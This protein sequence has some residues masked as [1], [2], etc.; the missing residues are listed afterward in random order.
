M[1]MRTKGLERRETDEESCW[2]IVIFI[3]FS[4]FLSLA[5]FFFP[6]SFLEKD[7]KEEEEEEKEDVGKEGK[8][9]T[10]RLKD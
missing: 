10:R 7:E 9:K 8:E 1:A 4:F 2:Y 5:L 6:I 3:S